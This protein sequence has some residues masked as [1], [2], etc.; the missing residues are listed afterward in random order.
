[1]DDCWQLITRL[2]HTSLRGEPLT[3]SYATVILQRIDRWARFRSSEPSV[4]ALPLLACQAAGGSIEQAVPVGAA[5]NM[6]HIAAKLF[7]DLEDGDADN[8]AVDLNIATAVLVAVPLLLET[9]GDRGLLAAQIQR[10]TYGAQRAVMQASAGQHADLLAS[11]GSPEAIDPD[12]WLAIARTKSGALLAWA[13][14]AGGLVGGAD[15]AQLDHFWTYGELLGVLLQIADDFVGIWQ[16][17]RNS[18][19][20]T[21]QLS[22]PVCY[23]LSVAAPPERDTLLGLL[24]DA[25]APDKQAQARQC[26][27]ELGAQAYSAVMARVFQQQALAALQQIDPSQERTQSLALLIEDVFPRLEHAKPT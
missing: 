18:D 14:W 15:E 21:G 17:E 12:R 24:A 22:L 20:V 8:P 3:E 13:A 6:L 7:D 2:L 26:L 16:P 25:A 11:Q 23:A 19:L 5:W 27:T 9:L 1:M 10:L 4:A